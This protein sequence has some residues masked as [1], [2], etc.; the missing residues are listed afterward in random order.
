MNRALVAAGDRHCC[1]KGLQN[2]VGVSYTGGCI[3]PLDVSDFTLPRN[4]L[5]VVPGALLI[6]KS[7]ALRHCLLM[8]GVKDQGVQG[9]CCVAHAVFER[10]GGSV[11]CITRGKQQ[12]VSHV[13][14]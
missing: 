9:F 14:V 8:H 3:Q 2:L 7:P 10:V 13:C 4:W 12:A 5:R 11:T 6:S 1:K